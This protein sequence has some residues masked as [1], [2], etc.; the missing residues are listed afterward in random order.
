MKDWKFQTSNIRC[1]LC[2]T[3]YYYTILPPWPINPNF[4]Y[5]TVLCCTVSWTPFDC[6]VVIRSFKV[7]VL[8][9]ESDTREPTKISRI[10]PPS[11]PVHS[12]GSGGSGGSGDCGSPGTT[13]LPLRVT[14]ILHALLL[15]LLL[16]DLFLEVGLM[17]FCPN[18]MYGKNISPS[19]Y[20]KTNQDGFQD[21]I[22]D[23]PSSHTE[24]NNNNNNNNNNNY[25]NNNYNNNRRS[26]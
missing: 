23:L 25:N 4:E 17:E 10:T 13:T 7:H 5:Y 19:W 9:W 2:L 21:E 11:I 6:H 14:L 12:G 3:L 16:S 20:F 15:L 22:Q 26:P 1:F 24:T 18:P 8:A